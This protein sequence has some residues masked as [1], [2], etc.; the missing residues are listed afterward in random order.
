MVTKLEKR[1][2]DLVRRKMKSDHNFIE[3]CSLKLFENQTADEREDRITVYSNEIGFNKSDAY[4]M[5]DYCLWIIFK[6]HLEDDHFDL[7]FN[8][9]SK[10][11]IQLGK[12]DDILNVAK[13]TK[14]V[15]DIR[16]E[17]IYEFLSVIDHSGKIEDGI[18]DLKE[19]FS[20]KEIDQF[21][22][23]QF[24]D[25]RKHNR[26]QRAKERAR[27]KAKEKRDAQRLLRNKEKRKRNEERQ[28]RIE[29]ERLRRKEQY[30]KWEAERRVTK[31][32]YERQ[33]KI[34]NMFFPDTFTVKYIKDTLKAVLI[35][36]DSENYWF[37]KSSLKNPII[38]DKNIQQE[39]EAKV[40]ILKDKNLITLEQMENL[41]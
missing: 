18:E 1:N 36:I 35:E 26:E 23:E 5:S 30:E 41:Y 4:I 16:N 27:L 12:F 40:W 28:K 3:V 22:L 38:P 34:D 7:V 8:R 33:K 29:T 9:I 24:L 19:H 17:I 31:E 2:G 32:K 15:K 20:V 37:P 11:A 6:D 21:T 14:K 10:Y 13:G 39:I 25:Y